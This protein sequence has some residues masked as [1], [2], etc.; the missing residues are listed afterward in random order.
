MYVDPFACTLCIL[1][2]TSYCIGLCTGIWR[3]FIEGDGRTAIV[4]FDCIHTHTGLFRVYTPDGRGVRAKSCTS[5]LYFT[6]EYDTTS[7]NSQS[8]DRYRQ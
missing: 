1:L 4:A 5:I 8:Y 3:T 6:P 7:I 2:Y